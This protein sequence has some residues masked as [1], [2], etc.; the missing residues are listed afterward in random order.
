[1]TINLDARMA[2]ARPDGFALDIHLTIEA[3]Q[4]V[5][6]LGPN[7]AGK[8]TAVDLLA[9]LLPLDEGRISLGDRLLDDGERVFVPPAKRQVGVVF[10][11]YLLFDHM[12]VAENIAFG[13]SAGGRSTADS[14][15][16]AMRW[17]ERFDLG[18][19]AN[20]K[21]P[22][23]SGG[24]AQRV[25]LARALATDPALLLLDEPLAA[26]DVETRST[27]RRLLGQHLQQFEGPRLLITHDPTDAFLL[28]DRIFIM[29]NG[30]ITQ[31]GTPYDIR[32]RPAT[33]YGAS[34][35]GTNLM[36]GTNSSGTLKLDEFDHLLQTSDTGVSGEVLITIHP[37]AVALHPAQPHGS[38]RNTWETVVEGIEPLG[39]TTRILLGAPL[40]ISVDITPAST[41]ALHLSIGTPIWA[42]VKA[43][44][45]AISPAN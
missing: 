9:G 22:G 28:A 43:T 38:P 6:L 8:S 24:Q 32:T 31:S 20:S 14:I 19:L 3:G 29:E 2:V 41:A 16:E 5:A 11:D 10:Q 23:L 26:L 13:I 15:T 4:T 18:D 25:A 35:A 36:T 7:G 21:P 1:M 33:S 45:I 34:V 42:S 44:E 37:R 40:P 30:S 17:A 27:T 12:T 39:D